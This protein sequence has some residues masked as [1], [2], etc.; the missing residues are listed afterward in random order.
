MLFLG[1]ALAQ[2]TWAKPLLFAFALFSPRAWASVPLG[3]AWSPSCPARARRWP[4][5]IPIA[6]AAEGTGS[7]TEEVFPSKYAI[8]RTLNYFG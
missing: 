2:F 8:Y 3:R 4:D 7:S 5:N 6:L 1:S